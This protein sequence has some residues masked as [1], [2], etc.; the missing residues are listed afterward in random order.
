MF[1]TRL[2]ARRARAMTF[3]RAESPDQVSGANE[4]ADRSL[5]RPALEAEDEPYPQGVCQPLERLD[6]RLVPPALDAGD[7]GVAG[8]HAPSELVLGE[9]ESGA[10]LD[11]QASKFLERGESL[12]LGTVGRASRSAP[13]PRFRG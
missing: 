1:A 5:P 6:A 9:P 13:G 10:V 11:H 7:G 4:L 12:L 2:Q 3:V 8:T